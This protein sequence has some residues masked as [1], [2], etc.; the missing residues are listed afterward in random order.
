MIEIFIFYGGRMIGTAFTDYF[1]LM[2]KVNSID[3]KLTV[4]KKNIEFEVFELSEGVDMNG[5]V[6]IK[7]N[8]K[9]FAVDTRDRITQIQ[10]ELL[11][12]LDIYYKCQLPLLVS[13]DKIPTEMKKNYRRILNIRNKI[14]SLPMFGYLKLEISDYNFKECDLINLRPELKNYNKKKY[15]IVSYS[16][17]NHS[18][19]RARLYNILMNNFPD[20]LLLIVDKPFSIDNPLN[21]KCFNLNNKYG[22]LKH[23]YE[24][25]LNIISSGYFMLNLSG[26]SGSNPHRIRDALL[27]DTCVISTFIYAD[28]Y[29]DFPC[30]KIDGNMGINEINEQKI[31]KQIQFLLDN[32]EQIYQENLIK[33]KEWFR[34]TFQFKNYIKY[35]S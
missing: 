24:D 25:Y 5:I 22:D 10:F 14:K 12:F 30:Y 34:S 23:N 4:I 3:Y 16:A 32:H 11:P 13:Y 29:S 31:I 19:G 15:K 17:G 6:I 33:Q 8:G 1:T 26:H 20:D 35:F 28:A 27:T 21:N 2:L 7:N 18:P 9:I